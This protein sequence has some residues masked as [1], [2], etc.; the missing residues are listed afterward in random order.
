MMT[1][2][3]ADND[4]TMAANATPAKTKGKKGKVVL[5]DDDIEF[6]LRD[7]EEK[8]LDPFL[9]RARVQLWDKN[10]FYGEIGGERRDAFSRFITNKIRRNGYGWK[11]Y[12]DLLDEYEVDMSA[13][14][15]TQLA[16]ELEA[17]GGPNDAVVD[18]TRAVA[19]AVLDSVNEKK[20]T[21]N[22]PVASTKISDT[23]MDDLA[24]QFRTATTLAVGGAPTQ[25]AQ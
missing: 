12:V 24:N 4:P 11:Q 14:T 6:L 10:H 23:A 7:I 16:T 5:T 15:E 9:M 13:N 22:L 1:T 2:E 20:S 21:L 8:E 19:Y 17:K 3:T 25:A 18:D